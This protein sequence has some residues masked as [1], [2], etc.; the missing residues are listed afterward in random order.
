MINMI[1][2]MDED[3]LI[4]KNNQMPWHIKEDLIYYKEKTAGKTVLMGYNTYESLK[5][6]YKDKPLPYGKIYVATR[7]K[8]IL[9]DA[10]IVSMVDEFIKGYKDEIWVCGGAM[11]YELCL[12][13]ADNLYISFIKGHHDGDTYFPKFDLDSYKLGY[14]NDSEKVSYRLY[15]KR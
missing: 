7:R 9:P 1:W 8:M 13:Y 3:W 10:E 4:G 15:Q 6:Y 2:A 11:L 14:Q 5:G 12:P